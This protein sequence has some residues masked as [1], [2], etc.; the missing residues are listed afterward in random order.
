MEPSPDYEEPTAAF[1][2]CPAIIGLP[3]AASHSTTPP[4][5]A[6]MLLQGAM[7]PTEEMAVSPLERSPSK[8]TV[9]VG[10]RYTNKNGKPNI[11]IFHLPDGSCYSFGYLQ[12]RTQ[13]DYYTC[14]E[15]KKIKGACFRYKVIADE[16]I[17]NPHSNHLCTPLDA[18][19]EIAKRLRNQA[20]EKK[21]RLLKIIRQEGEARQTSLPIS[22]RRKVCDATVVNENRTEQPVEHVSSNTSN[23]AL[24]SLS[25]SY[26]R[27]D[28]R[29]DSVEILNVVVPEEVNKSTIHFT[30]QGLAILTPDELMSIGLER[31]HAYCIYSTLKSRTENT[32]KDPTNKEMEVRGG[33][34]IYVAEANNFS[35][36]LLYKLVHLKQTSRDEL[37]SALKNCDIIRK[38]GRTRMF[39]VGPAGIKVQ[40][41]DQVI[42]MWKNESVFAISSVNGVYHI[43]SMT[44]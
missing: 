10:Q 17:T 31:S 33:L 23:S 36:E 35:G 21:L 7:V 20:V 13:F 12:S 29:S 9:F 18:E 3:P 27:K 39:Y 25:T 37:Y 24:P 1:E 30:L 22:K 41:S 38:S 5:D 44:R 28:S 2:V 43:Q 4:L 16:F 15:C 40:M 8:E 42:S 6:H 26:V 11:L 19:T 14:N 34:S 32:C